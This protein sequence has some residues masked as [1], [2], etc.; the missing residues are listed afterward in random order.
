MNFGGNGMG[1]IDPQMMQMLMARMGGG[2][3]PGGMGQGMPG[4]GGMGRMQAP[5]MPQQPPAAPP[6]T[7]N[8]GLPSMAQPQQFQQSPLLA[9]FGQNM[10]GLQAQ[11]PPG[12]WSQNRGSIGNALFQFGLNNMP[13]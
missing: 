11:D 9:N 4:M 1:G 7:A 8:L 13:R 6:V 5:Q 12:W 10:Q 3:M 2:G